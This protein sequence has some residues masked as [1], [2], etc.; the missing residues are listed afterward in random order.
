MHYVF[1]K[2]S[3]NLLN[4]PIGIINIENKYMIASAERAACDM[5]Y[6]HKNYYFDNVQGFD[7]D[8]LES[9]GFENPKIMVFY[10]NIMKEIILTF[11]HRINTFVT[12]NSKE[13]YE[14]LIKWNPSYLQS[15]YDKHIASFLGITP[16]TINRIKK[17]LRPPIK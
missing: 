17:K 12:M 5:I 4:N 8:K 6:L 14:D 16:L 15:T 1:H 7:I 10:I 11:S 9:I 13:R 3:D 2:L